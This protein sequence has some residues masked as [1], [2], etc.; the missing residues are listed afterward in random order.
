MPNDLEMLRWA[1]RSYAMAD[2]HRDAL[3]A[4]DAVAPDCGD[5]G[6]AQVLERLLS[7]R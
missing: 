3:T 4:A 7:L 6:V 2:G 5:D 1:G